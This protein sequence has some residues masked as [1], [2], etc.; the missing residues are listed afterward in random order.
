M[1]SASVWLSGWEVEKA[2]DPQVTILGQTCHSFLA[3][4][5]S[6]LTDSD[7]TWSFFVAKSLRLFGKRPGFT[8]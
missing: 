6:G 5:I 8:F 4:V 2:Y 3:V 1:T 7:I